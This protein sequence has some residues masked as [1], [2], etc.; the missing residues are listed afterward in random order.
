MLN[1]EDEANAKCLKAANVH[2]RQIWRGGDVTQFATGEASHTHTH[3]QV[4]PSSSACAHP[5]ARSELNDLWLLVSFHMFVHDT[6]T[7]THKHTHLGL[8][9]CAV[10]VRATHVNAVA[11]L[12]SQTH[13]H[14][15]TPLFPCHNRL[16][17]VP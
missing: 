8:Y 14:T 1:E 5:N 6:H 10:L 11:Q 4:R 7:H 3:T 12:L 16:V 15:H 9:C 2:R 13:T 17:S